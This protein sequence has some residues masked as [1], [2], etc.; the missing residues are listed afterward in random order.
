MESVGPLALV[1][2]RIS[3]NRSR[4]TL[5][6]SQEIQTLASSATTVIDRK[7]LTRQSAHFLFERQ[8]SI[9]GPTQ[10]TTDLAPHV[11]HNDRVLL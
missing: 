5:D 3:S 11:H 10:T 8:Q 7:I 4:Q 2:V 9:V 1:F 6:E